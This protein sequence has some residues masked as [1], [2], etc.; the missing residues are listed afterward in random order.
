M[1]DN[2]IKYA[3]SKIQHNLPFMRQSGLFSNKDCTKVTQIYYNELIQCD[4]AETLD[5]G[6]EIFRYDGDKNIKKIIDW[7]NKIFEEQNL[8]LIVLTYPGII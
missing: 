4:R 2:D 3:L 7:K 5:N 8:Y 6:N 1:S